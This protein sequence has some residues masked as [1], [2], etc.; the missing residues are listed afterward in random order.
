MKTIYLTRDYNWP[1]EEYGD[2]SY[3]GKLQLFYDRPLIRDGQFLSAKEL[4]ELDSNLYPDMSFEM[5]PLLLVVA[6][7]KVEGEHLHV[8]D[9]R[10]VVITWP[11]VQDFF[12]MEGFRENSF[13]VNDEKGLNDFGSSAYF[14]KYA[15]I[16]QLS[17]RKMYIA[18][19]K[20]EPDEDGM[21]YPARTALYVEKPE[22]INGKWKGNEISELERYYFPEVTYENSPVPLIPEL[23]KKYNSL[24]PQDEDLYQFVDWPTVQELEQ[25]DGFKENS[26]LIIDNKSSFMVNCEWLNQYK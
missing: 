26:Y 7:E 23:D 19:D 17:F 11:E 10:Y 1:R 20:A 25:K 2:A 16:C 6:T 21:T 15:W 4:C 24:M 9:N 18:R 5:S 12:E 14:V 3:T 8:S 13:L 22:V